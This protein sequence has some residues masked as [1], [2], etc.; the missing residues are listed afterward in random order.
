MLNTLTKMAIGSHRD[1]RW[2]PNNHFFVG[3]SSQPMDLGACACWRAQTSAISFRKYRN[4]DEKSC[5][6]FRLIF[7]CVL[8]ILSM[9]N[10]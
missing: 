3:K 4:E 6:G 1:L 10:A 2:L 9:L 7:G 8:Y 5:F